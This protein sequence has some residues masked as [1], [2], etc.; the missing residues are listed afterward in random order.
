ME[1][2]I[3]PKLGGRINPL[4]R[5]ERLA[6][7]RHSAIPLD[8]Q[9]AWLLPVLP[10][11][12]KKFPLGRIQWQRSPARLK[13][14]SC[15]ARTK[16]TRSVAWEATISSS[17]SAATTCST[18]AMITISWPAAAAAMCCSAATATTRWPGDSNFEPAG[19]DTLTGG[20]GNDR[21]EW[22][23]FGGTSTALITDVV[24]DFQGAGN[25]VGDTLELDSFSPPTR[26]TF[27]GQLAA[28][29]ALGSSIGTGGDGLAAIFYAFSG[30]NTFVL[31]DTNDNGT[32][33][34]GRFHRAPDRA[35]Q[36]RPV[37]LRQHAIR[38]CRHQRT[39]HD[40][41]HRGERHDPGL[42]RQ[43]HG[44]RSRRR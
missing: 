43:R 20:A 14:I 25:A 22:D 16:T 4:G 41:R 9:L 17:A 40:Q 32:Y 29:P 36:P 6:V 8:P 27:G 2:G 10:I 23:P 24:T 28:M 42:G 34:A 31:A 38:H 35:A 7:R 15:L 12:R 1:W 26:F 19:V 5:P 11:A 3:S 21:F 39:G 37:G 18:A 30:G 44:Q 33:D 13:A